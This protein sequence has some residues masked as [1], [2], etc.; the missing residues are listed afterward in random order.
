MGMLGQINRDGFNLRY[1]VEGKGLPTLVIGSAIYYPRSF[2]PNL[3]SHL[4]MAFIDWR[5][6]AE[7]SAAEITLDILLDDIEAMRERLNLKQVICIGHSAHALLALEYAKKYP[8]QVAKVV[9]IGISPNL[10]SAHARLAEQNWAESVWPERK[11]AFEERLLALPDE[12]LA[13]L[14]PP[15]RFVQWYIRRDPQA[16]YDYRFN[17]SFLWEGVVPNMPLFD[18]LYGDA[19]RSIEPGR[20][21]KPVFLALGRYDFIVAPPS[22]WDPFRGVFTDL[23][24]RIFERSG[25][26]P[27][28]EEA[29]LFDQE[30]LAWIDRGSS[31]GG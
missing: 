22:S 13:K 2:S 18:Y 25:H 27:Q 5:G 17:S 14:P 12:A 21:Q 28:Y 26:S 16:W 4:Q 15:E 31:L 30:L 29:P 8:A 10:S 11:R 3:R 20:F 1:Q 23:T 7:G 9:M 6:F 24:V 19:L